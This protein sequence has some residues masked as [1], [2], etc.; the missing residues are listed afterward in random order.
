MTG[1]APRLA[2]PVPANEVKFM[3]EHRLLIKF[4]FKVDNLG[5]LSISACNKSQEHSSATAYDLAK[6]NY[7]LSNQN[8]MSCRATAGAGA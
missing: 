2:S 5:R 4:T 8:A 3:Q 7:A 1:P 6:Q